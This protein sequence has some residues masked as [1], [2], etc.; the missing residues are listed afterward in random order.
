M[1]LNN[2]FTLPNLGPVTCTIAFGVVLH[3]KHFS[4][5]WHKS[6]PMPYSPGGIKSK[7]LEIKAASTWQ[8]CN[9]SLKTHLFYLHFLRGILWLHS[10]LQK[11]LAIRMNFLPAGA[12]CWPSLCWKLSPFHLFKEKMYLLNVNTNRNS[13]VLRT[14]NGSFTSI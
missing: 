3:S 10:C 5:L 9:L 12:H 11:Y 13:T 4:S 14:E 7:Q 2:P 1:G 6:L 8:K